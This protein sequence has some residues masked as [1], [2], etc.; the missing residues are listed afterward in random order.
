MQKAPAATQANFFPTR[1]DGNPYS[2]SVGCSSRVVHARTCAA[3]SSE[4]SR[5]DP[6]LVPGVN[7]CTLN[8]R[9]FLA[10]IERRAGPG[11]FR[12]AFAPLLVSPHYV[13]LPMSAVSCSVRECTG[14]QVLPF[15]F[16]KVH[17][18]RYRLR[19]SCFHFRN[20][21]L[22]YIKIQMQIW[23]RR[24]YFLNLNK[25]MNISILPINVRIVSRSRLSL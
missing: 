15:N 20:T 21:F 9:E 14:I 19:G 5:A 7:T 22:F 1:T 23:K 16:Q 3:Y 17:R 13:T 24:K 2:T 6:E 11:G 18:S 8:N 10:I 4:A 25:Y 12:C